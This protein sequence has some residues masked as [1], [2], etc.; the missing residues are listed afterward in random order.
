MT[1][2]NDAPAS[3][4]NSNAGQSAGAPASGAPG[5]T[6]AAASAQ[7]GASASSAD[8]RYGTPE[9]G[10]DPKGSETFTD[11][12]RGA[13][14][15]FG[16]EFNLSQ[17]G[18][19]RMYEIANAHAKTQE[20]ALE[21]SHKA[22]LAEWQKQSTTDKEFGGESYEANR[23]IAAKGLDVFATPELRTILKDSGLEFHPEF[24][25]FFFRVGKAV[26]EDKF[27]RGGSSGASGNK[28]PLFSYPNSQ[29]S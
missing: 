6:G 25:R 19:S 21:A 28:S 13:M 8:E 3:G 15:D 4:Q 12:L 1:T 2:P 22:N 27:A 16:K 11:G 14:H 9:K 24:Q 7:G 17:K 18:V 23:A 10:Y 29:H 20:Q 26:S 5:G